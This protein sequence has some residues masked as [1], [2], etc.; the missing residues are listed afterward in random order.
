MS[1]NIAQLDL[2][3]DYPASADH[4]A[5]LPVSMP[6]LQ[7][8]FA[9]TITHGA[10]AI[11]SLAALYYLMEAASA[12]GSTITMVGVAVYG[13]TQLLLYSASTLYHGVQQPRAKGIFR[14]ADHVCIYL[15]IAGTYTPFLLTFLQGPWGYSLLA[16]VW[17]CA[18]MGGYTR[19]VAKPQDEMSYAPYIATG[20]LAVLAAKPIY[21]YAPAG[22]LLLI[23]AGGLCFTI[24]VFFLLQHRRPYYHTIWHLWV[25]AG[26]TCH[27]LAILY[28]VVP[29][30][31]AM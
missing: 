16:L 23:L 11:L 26:S 4:T 1:N 27:F 24:G 21:D 2:P 22:G 29:A 13:V 28:Y 8:E 10:G 12:T 3:A 6:A 9:N 18:L 7:E 31:A 19:I 15:L 20:W 5:Y 14:K 30:G 17:G 25:L